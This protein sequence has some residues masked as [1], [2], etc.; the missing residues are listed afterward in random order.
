[1]P[2]RRAPRQRNLSECELRR[3]AARHFPFAPSSSR[4]ARTHTDDLGLDRAGVA[5]DERGFIKVDYQ[6]ATNVSGIWA[7][8]DINGRGAFTHT[9][10][11]D[12][13]IVAANLLDGGKTARVGSLSRVRAVHR[14]AVG[15]RGNHRTGNAG[16]R[17]SGAGRPAAD[18]PRRSRASG[19]RQTVSCMCSWT[20]RRAR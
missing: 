13:E 12:Y 11:N 19:A 17:S 2:R 7:L 3:G 10:Y 15:A 9:S 18:V 6:L 4:G 20:A 14:S 5:M 8:G 1:M 16:Q